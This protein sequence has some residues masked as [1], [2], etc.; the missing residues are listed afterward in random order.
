MIHRL[1]INPMPVPRHRTRVAKI[2]GKYVPLAYN[3]P[4]YTKWKTEVARQLVQMPKPDESLKNIRLRCH[5]EVEQPKKT[6][7]STPRGDVDNYAKGLMD[8]ITQAN[9]WKDD[10]QVV[11]LST[12]KSWAPKGKP[13]SIRFI[14][15]EELSDVAVPE[16][17]GHFD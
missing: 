15:T 11:H 8:A 9:W 2:K 12:S 16:S 1:Y 4:D 3:D 14:I 13:G 10:S 6:K 7:L 17:V 5:F